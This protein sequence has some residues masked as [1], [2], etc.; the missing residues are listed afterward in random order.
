MRRS[1]K[2]RAAA[3]N[4]PFNITVED[5]IIPEYCPILNIKLDRSTGRSKNDSCTPS[6]DKIIPEKGYVKGNVQVISMLANTMKNHAT[7]E[8]L[9]T[10]SKN[11]ESYL[12]LY[13]EE[14]V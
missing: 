6:L 12:N 13:K 11:I 10:F 3:K 1:S 4:I 5:I 8:Q 2:H 7:K 14:I 9:L